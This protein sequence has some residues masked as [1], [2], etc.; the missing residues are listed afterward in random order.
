M[1]NLYNIDCMD[2]MKSKPDNYYDLAIV[3]PPYGINI[4]SQFKSAGFLETK[5]MFKQTKGI[6]SS[7]W[8]NAIPSKEYFEELKRVSVNQ[9]IW[10]GNYFLD[11]LG[12]TKCMISWDKMNGTNNMADFEIAWTSLDSRCRRFNMHH[13]SKGY[14][15][16]IHICQKPV[17]LYEWLLMSYAKEGDKILDTHGGSMS[18]AI[19]AHNLGFDLDWCELDKNYFDAAKNRFEWH[20]SQLRL[21]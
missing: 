8:D 21:F 19:A 12:S 3:D 2:F 14:G 13:F 9:I 6:I 18:I 10:G 1:I 5:S 4:L 11:Y 17:K 20:K 7:E 15:D 16:K